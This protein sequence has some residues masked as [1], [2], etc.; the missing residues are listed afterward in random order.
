MRL[1]NWIYPPQQL[2]MGLHKAPP[3]PVLYNVYIKGLVALNSRMLTLADDGLIYKTAS[4]IHTAVTAAQEQLEKVSHWWQE[5]EFEINPSKAQ[6]LWCTL[7]N[8][9]WTVSDTSGSTSTECWRTRRRSNQQNSGLRKDCPRCKPWLQKALSNVVCSC[10]IR[11]WYSA[12]LTMVWVSQLC[13]S[14]TCWSS[15]GCN[16]IEAIRYLLDLPSM[17]T[18]HKVE[19]VKAYLNAIQS[20]KN[21]LHCVVKEEKGRRLA[22]DKSWMGQAEQSIQHVWGLA[23]PKQVR[24]KKTPFSWVQANKTLLSEN[25]VTHYREWP[26]EQPMLKYKCLSKPTASHMTSW[27]TWTKEQSGWGYT[28]KQGGRT[29]HEDSGIHRVTTSS[30]TMEVEAV[31]HAIQWLVSQRV[32]QITHAIILTDSMNLPQQV[33]SAVGCPDWHTTMHSLRLQRLLWIYC[34]G[35]AGVSGNERAVKP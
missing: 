13:H 26:A 9:A 16:T 31:T 10:C 2:T 14:P 8:K 30:L 33:E 25:L 1:G 27:S 29:V 19:Q 32:A 35:H 34:P 18:R 15:A 21:P 24:E 4:D 20:P 11:V 12:S 17:E 28:V 7:N 3:S 6:A 23:E 5:T 22:T